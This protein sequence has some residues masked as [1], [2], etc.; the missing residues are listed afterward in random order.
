MAEA[1]VKKRD[2]TTPGCCSVNLGHGH[3]HQVIKGT[4]TISISPCLR[5]SQVRCRARTAQ[6]WQSSEKNVILL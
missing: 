2:I 3:S 5:T 4:G 1:P 6:A